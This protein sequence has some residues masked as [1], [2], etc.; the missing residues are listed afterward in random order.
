MIK[1]PM[2]E[3]GPDFDE[4][5][6]V[7]LGEKKPNRVHNVEMLIDEEIK[8]D[9]LTNDF[10]RLQT[11]MRQKIVIIRVIIES[12]YKNREFDF[13]KDLLKLCEI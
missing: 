6:A 8:K 9:F 7:L 5:S 1:I 2:K 4:L 13:I 11:E 10:I 3:P 12:I